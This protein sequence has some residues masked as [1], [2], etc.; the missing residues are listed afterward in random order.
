MNRL[1]PY[2]EDGREPGHLE[3]SGAGDERVH[4]GYVASS[5]RGSQVKMTRLYSHVN[6]GRPFVMLSTVH[7]VV[8]TCQS[9]NAF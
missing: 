4:V 8:V 9:V 6:H 2:C 3:V 5:C 7:L 1:E